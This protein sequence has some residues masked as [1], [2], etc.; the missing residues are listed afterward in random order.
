MALAFVYSLF[1][2]PLKHL[3]VG[4]T[5]SIVDKST[6]IINPKTGKTLQWFEGQGRE[7]PD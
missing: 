1:A 7:P 2:A 4:S 5:G 6:C 3:M